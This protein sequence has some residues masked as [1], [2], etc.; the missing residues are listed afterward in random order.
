MKDTGTKYFPM[1]AIFM[2]LADAVCAGLEICA[3]LRDINTLSVDDN[4]VMMRIR[5]INERGL[6]C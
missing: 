1:V 5:E 3:L 2:P 6:G 4:I